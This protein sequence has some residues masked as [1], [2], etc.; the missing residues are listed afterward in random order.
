MLAAEDVAGCEEAW[1]AS[2]DALWAAWDGPVWTQHLYGRSERILG[3]GHGFVGN[4]RALAGRPDL[5]GAERLAELQ[6]RT[7]EV[8]R[9]EA[10]RNGEL[11]NWSPL[12]GGTDPKIRVQWCHGAPGV[13]LARARAF[14]MHAIGQIDG[15]RFS[16]STGDLG[17][18]LYLQACLDGDARFPTIDVW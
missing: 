15:A 6:E 18:A 7:V 16:L 5:L 2:A 11:V 3:A 17:I 14:A 10:I 8:L 9:A 1:R 13:I 12:Y 4:V